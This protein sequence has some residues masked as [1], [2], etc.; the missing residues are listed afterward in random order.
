MAIASLTL[1]ITGLV[2]WIFPFLGF[3]IS[4]AGLVLGGLSLARSKERRGMAIVALVTCV[5]GLVLNVMSVALGLLI[6]ERFPD[7]IMY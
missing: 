4:T 1:G 3:P 5:V 2:A 7:F 6:L